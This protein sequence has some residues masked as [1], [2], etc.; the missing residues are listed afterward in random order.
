MT[1]KTFEIIKIGKHWVL[2]V[3]HTDAGY[4]PVCLTWQRIRATQKNEVIKGMRERGY[5]YQEYK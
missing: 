4:S 2:R 3:F 1:D 5:R